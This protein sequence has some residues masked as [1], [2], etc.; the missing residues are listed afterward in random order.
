MLLSILMLPILEVVI[1][2][3][4][5]GAIGSMAVLGKRVFFSESL[6]HGTFPGAV[7]GVVVGQIFG[8]NL[9][10]SLFIGAA[11]CCIPLALLMRYLA[12]VEGISATAAAGIV[13]TLGYS[14]GVFLL[15]WFQP[16]PLKVEGFLTGSLLSVNHMDVLSAV[17]V[18]SLAIMVFVFFGRKLAYY[19]FDPVS[20]RVS[21]G[22]GS[23]PEALRRNWAPFIA[24]TLT[25]SLLCAA[26]VVAIPAVGSILSIALLV[27]PAAAMQYHA[28]TFRSMVISSAIAG[29]V[30]GAIGLAI[31]VQ[32]SLSAGGTIAVVAGLFYLGSRLLGWLQCMSWISPRERKTI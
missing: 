32:W 22:K 9:S 24:E 13:L 1:V 21:H 2:G 5:M 25:L 28:H 27:A 14:M 30:I 29:V 6:S 26:M 10:L 17:I 3:S 20:F 8:T 4:L 18:A 12:G 7:L 16:L 23:S 19:Y 15:R 11:L 31:A